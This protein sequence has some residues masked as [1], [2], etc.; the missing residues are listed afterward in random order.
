VARVVNCSMVSVMGTLYTRQSRESLAIQWRLRK[1]NES[2]KGLDEDRDTQEQTKEVEVVTEDLCPLFG[3]CE[4][5]PGSSEVAETCWFSLYT[6][7]TELTLTPEVT[8]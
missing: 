8:L 3:G 1:K 6:S 2:S 5:C 4:N 7:A